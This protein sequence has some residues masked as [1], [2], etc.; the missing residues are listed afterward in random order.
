MVSAP[1]PN[2]RTRSHCCSR[3]R[4][5]KIRD[6]SHIIGFTLDRLNALWDQSDGGF[7]RY[8]DAEDWSQPGTE[9]TLEDNAALLHV[10]VEAAI[11]GYRG[12]HERA[13]AVVQWAKAKMADQAQWRLLQ[14]PD[15]RNGIDDS[16]YVDRNAMMVGA[17]IRAAALFDD[18]WLRDFALKSL[19]SGDRAELRPWRWR[20]SRKFT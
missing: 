18:I 11:R 12:A 3:F 2:F 17:F 9:K 16:M 4:C 10:F 8:A 7:H 1:H 14:R 19:E 20:W 13:A 6:L 15:V 5:L